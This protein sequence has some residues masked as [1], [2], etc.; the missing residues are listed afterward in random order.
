MNHTLPCPCGSN[1]PLHGC[2]KP[3]IVGATTPTTAEQLMRSRYTAYALREIDWIERTSAGSALLA[4]D[5]ASAQRWAEAATFTQLK[6]IR[7]TAGGP[8]DASGQVEFEATFRE[9]GKT[10]ALRE[11]SLFTRVDGLW[12]YAG[13]APQPAKAGRNDPCPCGSGKKFK[14]CCAP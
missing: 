14:R 7:T 2:C 4:F 10:Q 1:Q 13:V 8:D 5:R 6:V 12:H 3:M 9:N 11:V